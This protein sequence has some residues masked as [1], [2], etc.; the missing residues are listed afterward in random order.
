MVAEEKIRSD[1]VE[2]VVFAR[3]D[4]QDPVNWPTSRKIGVVAM[5]CCL[6]FCS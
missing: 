6:S 2:V 3:D 1:E 4:P 5:L